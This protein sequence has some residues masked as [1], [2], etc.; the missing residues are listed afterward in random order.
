[1]PFEENV[2]KTA[3]EIVVYVFFDSQ[4]EYGDAVNLCPKRSMYVIPKTAAVYF[5]TGIF[6]KRQIIV[7]HTR[8][9]T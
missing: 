5:S 1:M 9:Y 2:V 7:E 3:E 4:Q 6:S 8:R